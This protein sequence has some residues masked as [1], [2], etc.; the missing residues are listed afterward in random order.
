MR[1]FPYLRGVVLR[2]TFVSVDP[3]G[4]L[5]MLMGHK[6]AELACVPTVVPGGYVRVGSVG[7]VT[8]GAGLV[9]LPAA[10]FENDTVW[11]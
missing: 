11:S 5:L 4:K 7:G 1:L 8:A 3:A 6:P 10:T 9:V 2:T